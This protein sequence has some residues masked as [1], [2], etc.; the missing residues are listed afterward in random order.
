MRYKLQN[1]QTTVPSVYPTYSNKSHKKKNYI[2]ARN[3]IAL[4]INWFM[5]RGKKI[6]YS[7]FSFV[8]LI[9]NLDH[10]FTYVFSREHYR[11]IDDPKQQTS[12]SVFFFFSETKS[13]KI[14]TKNKEATEQSL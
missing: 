9:I 12:S 13:N 4:S 8:I 2:N 3:S 5:H 14:K 1:L 10:V 7:F 11:K 6:T